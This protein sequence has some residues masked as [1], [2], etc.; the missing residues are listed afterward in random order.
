MSD[1]DINTL[2]M[3]QYIALIRDNN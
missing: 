1:I 2:T 3:E